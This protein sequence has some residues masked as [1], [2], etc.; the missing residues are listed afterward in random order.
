M[1]STNMLIN[2]DNY[3]PLGTKKTAKCYVI[4]RPPLQSTIVAVGSNTG[5]SIS[6][7]RFLNEVF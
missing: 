2:L 3:L 4:A 1:D 6:V 5:R 7:A